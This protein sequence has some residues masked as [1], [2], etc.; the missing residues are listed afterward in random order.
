MPINNRVPLCQLDTRERES[1]KTIVNS[2]RLP[3]EY[4]YHDYDFQLSAF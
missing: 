2:F 3:Q 4:S 1:L